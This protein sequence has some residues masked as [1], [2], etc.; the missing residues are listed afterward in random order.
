MTSLDTIQEIRKAYGVSLSVAAAADT[1]I[2]T[3][4]TRYDYAYAYSMHQIYEAV[5]IGMAPSEE[6]TWETAADED[7]QPTLIDPDAEN[8]AILVFDY[9]MGNG[10]AFPQANGQFDL[11]VDGEK[12]LS[13]TLKKYDC[14]YEGLGGTRLYLEISKLKASP[15]VGESF[16]LDD[17]I[18]REGVFVT[19]LAYLYL[20]KA[21]LAG[22]S[23]LTLSVKGNSIYPSSRRW[24]RLGFGYFLL[25]N[26]VEDG[27]RTVLGGRMKREIDGKPV[28]MGDIHI[29]TAESLPL[30]QDGCG[31]RSVLENLAYARDVACLDFAAVT[32][33]DWQMLA[34]DFVNLRRCNES[35]N[36]DGRF[37]AINA[38]EW[39]SATYGHR[40]VY[41]KDGTE[42]PETLKPFDYQAEPYDPTVKYG[43][44][45]ENDP[46]PNDLFAWLKENQLEAITIPHHPSAEQFTMDLFEFFSEEYDRLVEVYSSWGT[47]IDAHHPVNMNNGHIQEYSYPRYAGK[48]HFGFVASSDGHDGYGGDG[49]DSPDKHHIAHWAGSGRVCVISPSLSRAS[50]FEALKNRR[51]YAVTGDPILVSFRIGGREMGSLIK[52]PLSDSTHSTDLT[53]H[54]IGTCRI[55][56]ITV[57]A[58]GRMVGHFTPGAEAFEITCPIRLEKATSYYAEIR[59]E[60]GEYAWTSPITYLPEGE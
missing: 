44:R 28:F 55:E 58:N 9:A 15:R 33:H 45:S 36:E 1:S 35:V 8:G 43:V 6:I 53:L 18:Q 3:N 26:P 29:H 2:K 52:E 12:I 23:Q 14:V 47:F 38:F 11:S 17:H 7:F 21:Y 54:V 19:G 50:I 56:E 5:K 10:A 48:K 13:F 34:E 27:V 40:N 20:P 37:T 32:D 22:R 57:Y 30:G 51:C 41:F 16:D 31:T 39:T 4:G 25:D 49:S 59:Q 42:I 24:F 46:N 60:D